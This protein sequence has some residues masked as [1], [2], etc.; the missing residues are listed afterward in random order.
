LDLVEIKLGAMEVYCESDA[1]EFGILG[2]TRIE[3]KSQLA[4]RINTR[5]RFNV[6]SLDGQIIRAVPAAA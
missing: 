3:L 1:H 2:V 4:D 5:K 6:V